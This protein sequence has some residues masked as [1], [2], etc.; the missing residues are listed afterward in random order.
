MTLL[1]EV[2]A[3]APGA[4]AF[5]PESHERYRRDRSVWG[6]DVGQ[7]LAIARPASTAE[8]QALVT[9]ARARFTCVMRSK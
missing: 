2:L 8:V 4:V 3:V 6:D 5:D 1:D 9:W 7:P